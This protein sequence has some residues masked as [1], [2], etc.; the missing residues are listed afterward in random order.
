MKKCINHGL[1]QTGRWAGLSPTWDEGLGQGDRNLEQV[2]E[3]G[4]DV[5][6]RWPLFWRPQLTRPILPLARDLSDTRV[7][8]CGCCLGLPEDQHPSPDHHMLVAQAESL[9]LSPD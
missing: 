3:E 5:Y 1:R 8:C 2:G 6:Q 9:C 7:G 4:E